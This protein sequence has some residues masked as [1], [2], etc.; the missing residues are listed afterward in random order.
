M[1]LCSPLEERGGW[2]GVQGGNNQ[3]L[4]DPM[5]TEL[6]VK[7]MQSTILFDM[8]IDVGVIHT[9]KLKT[10]AFQLFTHIFNHTLVYCEYIPACMC[11]YD[12]IYV[13][14]Y[15]N[16]CLPVFVVCIWVCL[17]VCAQDA[18][19]YVESACYWPNKS[20]KEHYIY[21]YIYVYTYIYINICTY[22]HIYIHIYIY[23]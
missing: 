3:L 17:G 14:V 13:S 21:I 5:A 7:R 19:T 2:G 10:D 22:I 23:V 12:C 6:Q 11:A 16:I 18:C 4:E 1:H 9:H 20:T 15:Q 8:L